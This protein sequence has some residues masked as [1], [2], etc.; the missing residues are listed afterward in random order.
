[1]A[2]P[3]YQRERSYERLALARERLG[4]QCA[5]CSSQD[6]LEFD[7]IDPATKIREVSA[8]TNW[9]LKRFL[10]EVDKCQLLCGPCHREK[11]EA[12]GEGGTPSVEHGGGLS[13]KKN[14]PCALCRARRRSYDAA[15]HR[16]QY[17][18]HPVDKTPPEHGDR[19]RYQAGCHCELCIEAQR[20]YMQQYRA[21]STAAV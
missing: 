15:R 12:N 6:D 9:S 20:L 17:Q 18:P 21:R 2:S 16:H 11:T 1:M 13:G 19:R 5:R 4:G 3:E 8:C 10:S 7:H 14:C